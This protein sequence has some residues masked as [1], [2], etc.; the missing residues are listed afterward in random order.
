MKL[1]A[2]LFSAVAA[3]AIGLATVMLVLCLY[4]W[5]RGEAIQMDSETI[6]IAAAISFV[7]LVI[8]GLPMIFFLCLANQNSRPWL[9]SFFG[10]IGGLAYLSLGVLMDGQLMFPGWPFL[11]IASLHGATTGFCYA[12][13]SISIE[14]KYGPPWAKLGKDLNRLKL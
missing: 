6:G 8:I 1:L 9:V 5:I 4:L 3:Q 11:F 12:M 10:A 13:L 2:H 7:G 14:G